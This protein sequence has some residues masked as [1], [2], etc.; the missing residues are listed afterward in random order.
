MSNSGVKRAPHRAWPRPTLPAAEA[1]VIV[2]ASKLAPVR[3]PRRITANRSPTNTKPA[4]PTYVTGIASS[5]GGL[6]RMSIGDRPGSELRRP[7][8]RTLYAG[9]SRG[10]RPLGPPAARGKDRGR[11]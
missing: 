8:D 1:V 10:Q 11:Q 3:R 7:V 4:Q 2:G 6:E 5:R 9:S